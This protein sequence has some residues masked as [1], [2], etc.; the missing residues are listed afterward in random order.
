MV[1]WSG[2]DVDVGW[3]GFVWL[4]ICMWVNVGVVI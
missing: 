3:C 4:G 2:I 1:V